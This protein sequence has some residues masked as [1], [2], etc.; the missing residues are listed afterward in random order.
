MVL[1]LNKRKNASVSNSKRTQVAYNVGAVC[2]VLST[3]EKSSLAN[4]S[5]LLLT[6]ANRVKKDAQ[7]QST[8]LPN[9]IGLLNGRPIDFIMI[10]LLI[11][12]HMICKALYTLCMLIL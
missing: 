5:T 8:T 6:V 3:S 1:L 9:K 2:T 11:L 7:Q 12:I 4:F 10:L